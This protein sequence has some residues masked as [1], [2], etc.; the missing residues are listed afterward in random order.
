MHRLNLPVEEFTTP[1]PITATETTSIESLIH[2]MKDN[3]VRHLPIVRGSKVV[4]IVSDRDVRLASGLGSREK[5]EIQAHD[6][7]VSDP[8]TVN[9]NASLDDVAFEMSQKK[10]G[11]VIVNDDNENFVGIFTVT[12]ALNALIEI[13]RGSAPRQ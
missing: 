1:D 4:G 12:D 8:V 13:A 5:T 10:I 7:M 9:A 11:S 3:G 2:M 6:I